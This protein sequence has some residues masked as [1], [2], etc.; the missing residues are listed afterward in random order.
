MMPS[1]PGSL[2][3]RTPPFG[4]VAP[5]DVKQATSSAVSRIPSGPAHFTEVNPSMN[6]PPFDTFWICAHEISDVFRAV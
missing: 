4:Q 6:I 1:A 5:D 3:H 2:R